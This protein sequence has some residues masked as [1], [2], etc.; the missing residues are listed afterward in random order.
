MAGVLNFDQYIGG[1][2][3]V[4][5][6]Q[7]FPS[8]QRTL[9]YNFNKDITGWAFKADYQTLVVDAIAF[10]RNTGAPNFSN[11]S[12]IGSFAKEDVVTYTPTVIN[13]LT[14]IV[15][16]VLPANMYPYEIV[17]DAR[18]NVPITV[19][20]LTWSDVNVP[21]QTVSHRW[22]LIMCYEPGVPIGDPTKNA[23]FTPLV[24]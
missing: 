9:I 18:Q 14:G 7:I 20:S 13:A 23:E 5:V 3:Q 15:R 24:V 2:D 17:P 22:A 1:P 4:K 21:V 16:V 8:N 12:V 11:S 6:E 10:N 19:F